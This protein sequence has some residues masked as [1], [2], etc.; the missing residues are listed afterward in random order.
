MKRWASRTGCSSGKAHLIS[1]VRQ[2]VASINAG[3]SILSEGAEVVK[4]ALNEAMD[5]DR[6]STCT[7]W[8]SQDKEA[9]GVLMG[10]SPFKSIRDS[11]KTDVPQLLQAGPRLCAYTLRGYEN[12]IGEPPARA[13]VR[14]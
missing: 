9:R 14:S 12:A 7:I 5:P 2:V 3:F 6:P 13:G 4:L 1:L 10:A 8:R 11:S